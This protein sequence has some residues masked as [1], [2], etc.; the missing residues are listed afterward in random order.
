MT[1]QQQMTSSDEISL[2]E[3]V[4][5]IREWIA[6]LKTQ[7]WKIAV[8]GLLGGATGFIYVWM[9]P[10]TYTARTT[11]VVEDNK[12][13]GNL[14]GLA[15]L[16]GQF[17]FDFGSNSGSGLISGDNII[18]Y[19]KSES[20]AREVL[21][22]QFDSISKMS[23]ADKYIISHGLKSKWANN[24]RIGIVNF[25]CNYT[26][27]LYTRLQDSLLTVLITKYINKEQLMVS[28]VD[29]KANFIE[30]SITTEDELLSKIYLEVLVNLAVKR[31][32]DIKTL[33]QQKSVN[34]LQKRVDSIENIL[35]TKTVKSVQLQISNSTMDI[36]PLYK[37]RPSIAT[38]LNLRD[39]GVLMAM[40]AEATKNLELAKITLSQETPVIQ[41]VDQAHLPLKVNKYSLP[42]IIALSVLL[43]CTASMILLLLA[44][45]FKRLII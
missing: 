12:S 23:I 41:I 44:N 38:E 22:S 45:Q 32:V 29:K 31:Y 13:S 17:G 20:L 24:R 37:G 19:F 34:N 40:Y 28:R 39:K 25:P 10:I 36:N 14:G 35:N 26:T 4:Q 18:H 15:S 30:I 11:F 7:W 27:G 6:Y 8:A 21:T 43:F 9:K 2:K 33:R 42:I 16:A 3:L 1:E 5:K